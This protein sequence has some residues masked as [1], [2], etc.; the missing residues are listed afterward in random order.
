MEP[1]RPA[2]AYRVVRRPLSP[3]PGRTALDRMLV[4]MIPLTRH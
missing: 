4:T 1:S 2:D 3:V